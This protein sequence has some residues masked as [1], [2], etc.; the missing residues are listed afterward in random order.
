MFTGCAVTGSGRAARN[1]EPSVSYQARVKGLR[2]GELKNAVREQSLTMSLDKYPPATLRQLQKRADDDVPGVSGYLEPRRGTV[3]LL[4]RPFKLTDGRIEFNGGWPPEPSLRLTA[5][6]TRADLAA[7]VRI[8]GTAHDPE[9]T[10]TSEPSLPEDEILARILFGKDMAT[11]TPLQALSLASEA[12]K[13]RKVG[14][15]TGWLG[16]APSAVG[17]D[18]VEFREAGEGAGTPEVAAGKYVGDRSYVEMR[19]AT[20]IEQPGR[21]RVYLEHE[22]RPNIVLEAESGLEMRSGLGL[23][24]KRDY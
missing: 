24:W 21:V 12:A 22:L 11:V 15:G 8:V 16:D 18:R 7:H 2:F 9:I 20:S 1:H 3:L 5:D 6:F 17:I 23:F 4:K 14:G 13:L 19:R 10:L